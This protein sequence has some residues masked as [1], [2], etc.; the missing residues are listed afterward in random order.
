M[1]LS[2]Y[3]KLIPKNI[4]DATGTRT[5]AAGTGK[6][7]G[8]ARRTAKGSSQVRFRLSSARFSHG[9][10]LLVLMKRKEAHCCASRTFFAAIYDPFSGRG[11]LCHLR[12]A[13]VSISCLFCLAVLIL[14]D[15]SLGIEP[16]GSFYG[17]GG[18]R[19]ERLS[20]IVMNQFLSLSRFVCLFCSLNFLSAW[21]VL[22]KE[23]EKDRPKKKKER[24]KNRYTGFECVTGRLFVSN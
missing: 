23:R 17:R 20:S 1:S 11:L 6:D 19:Q 9:Y 22:T 15:C 3:D 10:A 8:G 21:I 12:D 24:K 16:A 2:G 5:S 13:T 14:K 4:L 7:R 18:K